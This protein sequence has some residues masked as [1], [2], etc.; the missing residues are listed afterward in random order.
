MKLYRLHHFQRL[1]L[2]WD[3]RPACVCKPIYPSTDE[4]K[5]ARISEASLHKL[6]YLEI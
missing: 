1:T 4:I 2:P 3:Y 5:A 6:S